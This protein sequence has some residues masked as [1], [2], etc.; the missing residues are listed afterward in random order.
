[1]DDQSCYNITVEQ[2]IEALRESLGKVGTCLHCGADKSHVTSE[3][4]PDSFP[5][6]VDGPGQVI[7]EY[8]ARVYTC[9]SCGMSWTDHVSEDARQAAVDAHLAK[10]AVDTGS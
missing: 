1:M 5:Y 8:T 3:V 6:G 7:L 10:K 9:D 2:R 4:R